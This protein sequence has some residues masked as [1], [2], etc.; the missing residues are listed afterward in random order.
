MVAVNKR[1]LF[2]SIDEVRC[3]FK[4]FDVIGICETWLN[5][6]YTDNLVNIDT[7]TLFRI[8]REEGNIENATNKNKRGGGLA[9]YIGSKFK[10]HCKKL[11]ACSKITTDLE[12]LWVI[13]EKPNVRNVAVCI[14]YK[15]PTG[16]VELALKQLTVSI[17]TIQ[18]L[19]DVEFVIMGDMNVN[20]RVRH[21]KH[22]EFLKEFKHTQNLVQLIAD[23]Y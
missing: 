2:P 11:D 19:Y 21:S 18:S 6:S 1:S 16:D 3:K 10:G 20:Y 15:P 4:D 7:Y 5:S 17:K 8:D 12:Q 23:P 13:L 22:F 14:L 9:L